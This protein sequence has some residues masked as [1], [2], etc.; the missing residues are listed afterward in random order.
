MS[1]LQ[2]SLDIELT[3]SEVL[4]ALKCRFGKIIDGRELPPMSALRKRLGDEA[5]SAVLQGLLQARVDQHMAAVDAAGGITVE[6]KWQLWDNPLRFKYRVTYEVFPDFILT[7]LDGLTLPTLQPVIIDDAQIDSFIEHF[8]RD[9]S[10]WKSVARPSRDGDRV[11]VDF[12]G[13]IEGQPFP[14]GRG[15]AAKVELGAGGMLPEFEAQ[16]GGASAAEERK[17]SVTFPAD[18]LSPL[19]AGKTAQF[20]VKVLD[21]QEI[22]LV[23][24]DDAFAQRFGHP[25]MATLRNKM[26][27]SLEEQHREHDQ[28]DISDHLLGQLSTANFIPL[29]D[30]LISQ[31]LLDI[32]ADIARQRG[33]SP[34]QVE[35]DEDMIITARR[36]TQLNILVRKLVLSEKIEVDP[37]KERKRIDALSASSEN[38]EA[39]RQSG[40]VREQLHAELLQER[41]IEWLI[42]RAKQ[43]KETLQS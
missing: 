6:S 34:D 16:L 23:S 1:E 27:A 29:P 5:I 35:L 37:E 43:N 22:E 24:L 36:R 30:V 32:Q 28:R 15:T 10:P 19:L 40:A 13:L 25:D 12:V 26:R 20:E 8:R 9:R 7:G 4:L 21:V 31:H 18:Y 39:I 3:H 41:V 33:C 42:A 14:G 11:I 2:R 17:F 38:A